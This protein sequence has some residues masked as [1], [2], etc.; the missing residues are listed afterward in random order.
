MNHI[1][2]QESEADEAAKE[3]VEIIDENNPDAAKMYVLLKTLVNSRRDEY[4][5]GSDGPGLP[6]CHPLYSTWGD[7]Y[8]IGVRL[9]WEDIKTHKYLIFNGINIIGWVKSIYDGIDISII[10]IDEDLHYNYYLD[11]LE[12]DNRYSLTYKEL[13]LQDR[14]QFEKPWWYIKEERKLYMK[15]GEIYNIPIFNS[16]E[17]AYNK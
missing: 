1:K 16:F 11:R 15:M 14:M 7:I 3:L 2:E 13:L 8:K 9:F 6:S 17:E 12:N 5:I 10:L 4:H